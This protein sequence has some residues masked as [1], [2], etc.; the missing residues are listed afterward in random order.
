MKNYALLI[1]L[2]ALFGQSIAA[3]ENP[4]FSATTKAQVTQ[5]LTQGYGINSVNS[6]GK[7]PL[8][9]AANTEKP[10]IF[11]ALLDAGADVHAIDNNTSSAFDYVHR[12]AAGSLKND[13]PHLIHMMAYLI[14]RGAHFNP[15]SPFILAILCKAASC[16]YLTG[17]KRMIEVGVQVNTLDHYGKTPLHYASIA[18]KP[19]SSYTP[20][21]ERKLDIVRCLLEAHADINLCSPDG[22]SALTYAIE[23]NFTALIEL[24]LTFETLNVLI[25]KMSNT[26]FPQ[27]QGAFSALIERHESSWWKTKRKWREIAE[28]FVQ[29]KSFHPQTAT[30]V[31]KS[32]EYHRN[33]NTK[34]SAGATD[35]IHAIFTGRAETVIALIEAKADITATDA[36]GAT[37]FDYAH[38]LALQIQDR[39]PF[40]IM[41]V[42]LIDKGAPFNPQTPLFWMLAFMS[43]QLGYV[44]SVKRILEIGLLTQAQKDETLHMAAIKV[45]DNQANEN[46]VRIARCLLEAG[47]NINA[48]SE[49]TDQNNEIIR[50]SALTYAIETDFKPMIRFLLSWPTIRVM[51]GVVSSG[52]SAYNAAQIACDN[53]WFGNRVAWGDIVDLIKKHPTFRPV[54]Q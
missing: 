27:G 46:K 52:H 4:L 28:A 44:E 5:A 42:A 15:S 19:E 47:A 53:T 31:A 18:L 23:S 41:M 39:A 22:Y 49:D 54:E 1:A 35:L 48:L 10:D 32:I 2:C 20:Y 45:D 17:V 13:P 38:A 51:I 40:L 25:G 33:I 36:Q 6:E 11:F 37:A 21:N 16:G 8:I 50:R 7:T 30:E 26:E 43:A 24:L 9:A 34:D 12:N 29:H 14:E 3:G